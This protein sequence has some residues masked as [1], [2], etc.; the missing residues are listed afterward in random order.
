ML[1]FGIRTWRELWTEFN[2]L[3]VQSR[4]YGPGHEG[5]ESPENALRRFD[6]ECEDP[7]V[8]SHG[9]HFKKAFLTLKALYLYPQWLFRTLVKPREQHATAAQEGRKSASHVSVFTEIVPDY[10][11]H[12]L[13]NLEKLLAY[14]PYHPRT[15]MIVGLLCNMS[16]AFYSKRRAK[17]RRQTQASVEN[18]KRGVDKYDKLGQ[19]FENLAN[20][21][22]QP[23]KDLVRC[24]RNEP[25]QYLQHGP[26]DGIDLTAAGMP[27][28]VA[29]PHRAVKPA[30]RSRARGVKRVPKL[31]CS[32]RLRCS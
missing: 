10:Q 27:V 17:N 21:G 7:D 11:D 29:R 20:A 19:R 5:V 2:V 30:A 24:F 9:Q 14:L 3:R 26:I 32:G 16:T 28:K 4:P 25:R 12:R 1:E 23:A 18:Y 31:V 15:R 6:A 22:S 13:Y 8:Y